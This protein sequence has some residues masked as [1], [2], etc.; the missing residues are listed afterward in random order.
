MKLSAVNE[1]KFST[2][3]WTRNRAAIQQLLDFKFFFGSEKSPCLTKNGPLPALASKI[4]THVQ[5]HIAKNYVIIT[6]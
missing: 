5:T 3:L 6:C 4:C 2:G 1:A